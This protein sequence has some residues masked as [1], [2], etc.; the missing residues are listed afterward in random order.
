LVHVTARRIRRGTA[1]EAAAESGLAKLIELHALNSFGDMLITIALAWTIFFAVPSGE[2][3]VRVALYLL[4][5]MAPFGL[6]APVLGP[7]LDR[8]PHR[9]RTAMQMSM[10]VR[11]VLACSS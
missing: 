6:L 10:L 1:A 11:A 9:R 3:L 8:M 4:G 5:T 7:L 2:A